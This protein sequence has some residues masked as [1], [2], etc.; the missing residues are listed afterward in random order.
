MAAVS[1]VLCQATFCQRLQCPVFSV[2]P[3]SP[4]LLLTAET[5]VLTFFLPIKNSSFHFSYF[6]S[7]WGSF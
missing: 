6:A 3:N 4:P 2:L 1:P 5:L 7:S